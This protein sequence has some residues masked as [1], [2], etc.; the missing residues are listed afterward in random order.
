MW[1]TDKHRAT[2]WAALMHSIARQKRKHIFTSRC[3]GS[4]LPTWQMTVTSSRTAHV[5]RCLRSAD[6]PTCV[7]PRT[8]SSY[9]DRTFAAAGPRLWN[10]L[11]VQLRNPD[12]SYGRF[13]RQLKSHLFGNDEHGAPWPSICSAIEKRFTYLLTYLLSTKDVTLC[14]QW[15]PLCIQVKTQSQTTTRRRYATE[16]ERTHPRRSVFCSRPLAATLTPV[17]GPHA[18]HILFMRLLLSA[19]LYFSRRGAYWD[20]LCRDVVGRW[21]VVTRVHWPNGAS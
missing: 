14:C 13:R 15:R 16:V 7:V 11:P 17:R 2:T 12:I 20:R 3:P 8:Y 10:S 18:T 4:R 19:S 5:A 1:R 6:V 9:G 21:L